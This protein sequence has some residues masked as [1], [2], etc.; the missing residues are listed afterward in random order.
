[1]R[2]LFPLIS[3]ACLLLPALAAPVESIDEAD[4]DVSDVSGVDYASQDDPQYAAQYAPVEEQD[5]IWPAAPP[6]W[7]PTWPPPPPWRPTWPPPPPWRP[8]WPPPPPIWRPTWPP[9]PWPR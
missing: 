8:T 2:L 4:L 7:R 5:T 6:P 9:T 3:A 1:M